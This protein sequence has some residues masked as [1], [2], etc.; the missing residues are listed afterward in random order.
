M[1]SSIGQ[2]QYFTNPYKLIVKI[3]KQ[4]S[5]YYR[6]LI[7]KYIHANKQFYDPH[8]TVIRNEIPTKLDLWEKWKDQEIQFDYENIICNDET[9]FWLNAY[10]EKLEDIREELGLPI[11][12]QWT[13]SPDGKHKFHITIA[14]RKANNG[15]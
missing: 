15:R 3:E 12:S 13:R 10:S 9:Y 14:N 5:D 7:P 4:I 11:S 2:L 8:I 1:F 6:S